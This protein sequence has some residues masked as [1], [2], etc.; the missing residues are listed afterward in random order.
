MTIYGPGHA[1]W[2]LSPNAPGV[3]WRGSTGLT[4]SGP[5]AL[6][7]PANGAQSLNSIPQYDEVDR[8]LMEA[9]I[10]TPL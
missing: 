5:A 4:P 8:R 2:E 6:L 9:A 10:R 7:R 1:P 3:L